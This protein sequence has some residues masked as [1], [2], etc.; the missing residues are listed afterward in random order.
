V[1]FGVF[2]TT[3][4][5]QEIV[6]NVTPEKPAVIAEAKHGVAYYVAVKNDGTSSDRF[7][8]RGGQLS[9]GSGW[10]VKYYLGAKPSESVEITAAVMAGTFATSTM[11]TGAITDEST[12]IRAEVF[13][14]KT[15]VLKGIQ[16]SFTLTF[17]SVSDPAAQDAVRI[18]GV[19]K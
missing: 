4:I 1:G 10:T 11:E 18:T 9:G 2:N 5:G 17:T 7:M 14:D 6:Q 3:G 12:M 19:A 16:A 13:A 8:V 15:V